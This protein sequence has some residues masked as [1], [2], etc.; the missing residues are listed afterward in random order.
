MGHFKGIDSLSSTKNDVYIAHMLETQVAPGNDGEL[1]RIHALWSAYGGVANGA[2]PTTQKIIH[3]VIHPR[4][5]YKLST[6][7]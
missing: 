7:N 4:L 5:K 6:H 2:S 3:Y 1:S